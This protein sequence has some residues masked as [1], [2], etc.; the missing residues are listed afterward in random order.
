MQIQLSR[1]QGPGGHNGYEK[2][3]SKGN[4]KGS[5]RTWLLH[6]KCSQKKP[7]VGLAWDVSQE[8]DSDIGRKLKSNSLSVLIAL[9]VCV[10]DICQDQMEV[11]CRIY[12]QKAVGWCFYKPPI[13]QEPIEMAP[14]QQGGQ[15]HT[16]GHM[17]ANTR[18]KLLRAHLGVVT[19]TS[20][21]ALPPQ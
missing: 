7:S 4:Q 18:N 14:W 8:H 16:A 15:R 20:G 2:V 12:Q 19:A 21:S 5:W 3:F 17:S 10:C 11:Y 1:G 13:D 6:L 9:C